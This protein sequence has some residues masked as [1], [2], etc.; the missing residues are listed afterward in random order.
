MP[1]PEITPS[2]RTD[3][4]DQ[5]IMREARVSN[6]GDAAAIDNLLSRELVEVAATDGGWRRLYRHRMTGSLWELSYPQS[7][8]HGGGP[9]RLCKLSLSTQ[10]QWR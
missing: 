10:N 1:E 3:L 7:H 2:D 9:R 4:M 6:E 8:M 5:W